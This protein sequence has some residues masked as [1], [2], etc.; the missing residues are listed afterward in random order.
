MLKI[1]FIIFPPKIYIEVW[2][3]IPGA[4]EGD[5][6]FGVHNIIAPPD[7]S[8]LA[9]KIKELGVCFMSRK[10]TKREK[11]IFAAG[12]RTG[13]AKQKSSTKRTYRRRRSY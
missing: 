5:I 3:G 10:L 6:G 4:N 2:V 13:A 12:C 7:A 11:E 1:F 9:L 8:R